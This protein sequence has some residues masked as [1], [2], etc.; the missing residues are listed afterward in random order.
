[1]PSFSGSNPRSGDI[2]GTLQLLAYLA[3]A[4]ALLVLDHRG[5]WLARLRAQAT[6][7]AQPLWSVAGLPA[8]F[9][10]VLSETAAT[11]SGLVAE[12]RTLR[13]ALLLSGARVARLQTA[14][15]ENE[16]LRQ[17][18]GA[19]RRGGLDVQLAPILD[20]DLDPTRQRLVLD[21]GTRD[22]VSVGQSVIDAGGLVGQIIAVRPGSATVLLITDPDHAVPVIVARTGVRLVAYGQGRSD[23]LALPNIPLS[24]D[25]KVGDVVI[26]SGLGGRFPAGFPVGKVVAL[27]PDDSHAFLVGELEP[28]AQLDRGRD[29][30]LLRQQGRP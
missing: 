23:R 1:M 10:D 25:L 24:G 5:G 21:A 15:A 9:G 28:A 27:H 30:L 18:L 29:V 2:T 17:L 11:R 6:V 13:N 7:L 22:G 14:A 16:R 12:N 3:L 26:T 4:V 20:I 8:R 19:E